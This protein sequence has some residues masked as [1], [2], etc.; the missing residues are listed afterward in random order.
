M[1]RISQHATCSIKFTVRR[2]ADG[3]SR[4]VK[5]AELSVCKQESSQPT[6]RQEC[7]A[8]YIVQLAPVSFELGA[9]RTQIII[10][11]CSSAVLQLG[12]C[13]LEFSVDTSKLAAHSLQL[14]ALIAPM[15]E[16][17]ERLRRRY[18]F[19]Y[20]WLSDS[21]APDPQRRRFPAA[22]GRPDAQR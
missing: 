15:R 20:S 13:C 17:S 5:Q 22:R 19:T 2:L 18:Q 8:T 4:P 1:G 7:N 16:L 11:F 21:S 14:T 9:C 6:A 3:A 10:I 12:A